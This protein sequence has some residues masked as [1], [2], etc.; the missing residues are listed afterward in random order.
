M[1]VSKLQRIIDARHFAELIAY[2]SIN[3]QGEWRADLRNAILCRTVVQVNTDTSKSG[4]PNLK[5][6][7][8]DFDKREMS[9][10][11][12]VRWAKDKYG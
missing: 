5:A 11:E 9:P 1:P 8:P 12:M 10:D 7:M 3:P 6:F 2:E 4:V